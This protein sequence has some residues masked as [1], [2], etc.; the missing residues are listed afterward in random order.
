[1]DWKII[2]ERRLFAAQQ[3]VREAKQTLSAKNKDSQRR[4]EA[5]LRELASAERFLMRVVKN[6]PVPVEDGQGLF[7]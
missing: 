6:D 7:S 5:A 3:E 4:Y 1:M 2:A